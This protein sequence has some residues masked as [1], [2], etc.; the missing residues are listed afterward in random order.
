MVIV[1]GRR[2]EKKGRRENRGRR[3]NILMRADTDGG[4]AAPA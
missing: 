1:E 3:N 4:P 2:E